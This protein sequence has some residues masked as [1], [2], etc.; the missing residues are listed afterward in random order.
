VCKFDSCAAAA[1]Q[2]GG[3]IYLSSKEIWVNVSECR[4]IACRSSDRGGALSLWPCLACG[5]HRSRALS[6]I[7]ATYYSFCLLGVASSSTGATTIRDTAC[8]SCFGDSDTVGVG[9][10]QLMDQPSRVTSISGFNGTRNQVV[11]SGSAFAVGVGGL[12]VF[13]MRFSTFARNGAANCLVFIEIRRP[14]TVTRVNVMNSTCQSSGEY[15]L[16]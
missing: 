5:I 6:C 8:R 13:D 9:S 14:G 3:A 11:N 15:G 10:F 4:F 16:V 7:A 12:F 1:G 2:I